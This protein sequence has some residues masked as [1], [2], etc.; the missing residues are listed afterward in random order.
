MHGRPLFA[1]DSLALGVINHLQ[2]LMKV[3]WLTPEKYTSTKCCPNF[4][5]SVPP[6]CY[7]LDYRDWNTVLQKTIVLPAEPKKCTQLNSTFN[8][9]PKGDSDSG[10][11]TPSSSSLW[12][13]ICSTVLT[14]MGKPRSSISGPRG[15]HLYLSPGDSYFV[16]NSI[17]T[18]NHIN[19]DRNIQGEENMHQTGISGIGWHLGSI[20]HLIV[21]VCMHIC[22]CI[23]M[24]IYMF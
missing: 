13:F 16:N 6:Q 8:G 4:R 12:G 9:I 23:Y 20:N 14:N 10:Q 3:G 2:K 17:Q 21:H 11:W 1:N 5:G 7:T 22:A 15:S 19:S 24:H 18:Q